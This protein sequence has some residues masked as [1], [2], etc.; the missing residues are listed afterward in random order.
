MRV[1]YFSS[2]CGV[3]P[4]L[5]V[6]FLLSACCLSGQLVQIGASDPQLCE[7]VK[8]HPNLV[9]EAAVDVGGHL[10]DPSG[11]ALVHTHLEIRKYI[12]EIKQ[13]SFRQLQTDGNGDFSVGVLPAGK[14]R[15][16][17]FARGFKQPRNFQCKSGKTCKVNVVP[18]IAP[19]DTFPESVCSPK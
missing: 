3:L 17:I 5:T 6:C 4:S 9:L 8:V 10:E 12:S 11:A 13:T 2:R 7:K 15:L 18:E 19:T 16:L 1:G 14:Y